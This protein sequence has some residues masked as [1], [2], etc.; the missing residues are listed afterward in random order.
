MEEISVNGE[1]Y[2][3]AS[4]LARDFGYT[5]DYLG[6]LCRGGQVKATLIGRSWYVNEDSLRQHRQGRYRS[7]SSKS[8]EVLR[9]MTEQRLAER[10]TPTL[11]G[12][13]YE[14]DDA[15][16]LPS[17]SKKETASVPVEA[18][19]TA[20]ETREASR[21]EATG[22]E[23]VS[24]PEPG[25]VSIRRSAATPVF[26]TIPAFPTKEMLQKAARPSPIVPRPVRR[27]RMPSGL[28]LA[29]ITAAI[30]VTEGV[31]LLGMAGLEKK[32]VVS[33]DTALVLYAFDVSAMR[34]T[35]TDAFRR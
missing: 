5:S 30:L 25:Q 21:S 16:L 15:D 7:T 22:S 23:V 6:Q 26:R 19:E 24:R 29:L 3:K 12:F 35:L 4:V 34:E 27:S 32:M 18:P 2:T 1:K 13:S 14:Q 11:K 9:Q 20:V 31:L 8:K 28:S 17:L 10:R 33:A